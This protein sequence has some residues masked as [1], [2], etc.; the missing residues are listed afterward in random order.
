MRKFAIAGLVAVAAFAF[1]GCANNKGS[2]ANMGATSGACSSK[3]G[4]C[5]GSC[6]GDKANMGAVSGEKSCGS[7]KTCG[8]KGAMGA[9]GAEKKSC[10]GDKGAMG[11]V[12]GEKSCGG[13]SSCGSK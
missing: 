4:K 13:K 10:G 9:V 12:S 8:D 7:G 6:K 2:D 3:E 11:A 1:A 5:C